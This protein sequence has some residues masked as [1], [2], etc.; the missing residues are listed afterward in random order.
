MEINNCF[1]SHVHFLATGLNSGNLNLRTISS[2][3]QIKDIEI[4]KKYF[5]GEFLTGFGWDE[6]NWQTH[7]KPNRIVLD[8]IFPNIPVMF[9]RGDGHSSWLNTLGLKKL[10]YWG[11]S[12]KQL[13]LELSQFLEKDSMGN[14]TG[15]IREGLHVEALKALP[16]LN[17]DEI[18]TALTQAISEF[19][20]SGITHIRDMGSD[21]KQ[22]SVS[23]E[24]AKQQAHP[25][26]V[27]HNFV[28]ENS[29]DF[30]RVLTEC[31]EA[32]RQEHPLLRVAGVKVYFDGSL[33]SETAL[34]SSPYANREDEHYGMAIWEKSAL[35][36]II[37]KTWLSEFEISVHCI[38]DRAAEIVA[39][40]CREISTEGINGILNLE[41]VE[42]LPHFVVQKLKPLHVRCHIQPCHFLTDRKWLKTKVGDLY[43]SCFP[44]GALEAAKIPYFFGSDSPI[45]KSS[46]SNNLKALKQS[47]EEGIPEFY[48]DFAKKHSC[49][50]LRAPKSKSIFDDFGNL[51]QIQF[52]NDFLG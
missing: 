33:G 51:K 10:G 19:H 3:E 24:L 26:F 29:D 5:R 17:S 8:K 40:I 50:D 13:P 6:N 38:G 27:I 52:G 28:C 15:I 37:K 35:K 44:W 14:P 48:G 21:L 49:Y 2:L 30:R 16:P 43:S 22:F 1:D 11:D 4:K 20:L 9:S 32:R 47:K 45:E 36:D 34:L 31:K 46:I 12:L 18:K 7:T 41:H 42:V 39:E 23:L 25:L